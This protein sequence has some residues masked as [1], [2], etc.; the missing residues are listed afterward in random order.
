MISF[1]DRNDDS[2]DHQVYFCT[3][4]FDFTTTFCG[5]DRT[6]RVIPNWMLASGQIRPLSDHLDMLNDDF[7]QWIV[8]EAGHYLAQRI[9]Q[10]LVYAAHNHNKSLEAFK[11]D[12]LNT[13]ANPSKTVVTWYMSKPDAI[14]M[15]LRWG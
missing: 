2:G 5:Y 7:R 4:L 12:P 15:K 6:M 11:K 3:S 14:L 13:K 1:H 10:A 8:T 9:R